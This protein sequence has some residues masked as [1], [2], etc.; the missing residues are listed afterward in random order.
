[1]DLIIR[2]KS[3]LSI[4]ILTLS[5]YLVSG[6]N[7]SWKEIA[8]EDGIKVYSRSV[9]DKVLKE[10][11]VEAV[12]RASTEQIL[13]VLG[14][15]DEYFKWFPNTPTS[16]KIKSE[17]FPLVYYVE[18]DLPWPADNRDMVVGVEI[19]RGRE[20]EIIWIMHCLPNEFPEKPG[21]VRTPF[22]EGHWK[23]KPIDGGKCLVH[24]Q[25]ISDPGGYVPDRIA[26]LA[27]KEIPL[28]TMKGLIEMLSKN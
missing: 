21:C 8:N 5:C 25:V 26:N 1:M 15:V 19:S 17:K 13:Q 9:E 11:R 16:Y 20:D 7:S 6:Q 18:K 3:A 22:M 23:I 2:M 14:N 28:R 4:I 24:Q 27:I 12:I 10:Y